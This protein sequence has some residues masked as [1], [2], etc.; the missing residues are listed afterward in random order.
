MQT[1]TL[2]QA[3]FLRLSVL[4]LIAPLLTAA[5]AGIHGAW[6][7]S[8]CQGWGKATFDYTADTV[9]TCL[10]SDLDVNAGVNRAGKTPL[11]GAVQLGDSDAVWLLLAA[12]ANPNK[13]DRKG[14]TPLMFAA[15]AG[16]QEII[17]QL[18]KAG[19]DPNLRNEDG[20]T[21]LLLAIEQE[22][23]AVLGPL[24]AAGAPINAAT[25]LWIVE[26]GP[27]TLIPS[28]AAAGVNLDIRFAGG[29]TL[30][31]RAAQMGQREVVEQLI[32]LGLDPNRETENRETALIR[33]AEAGHRDIV[34]YLLPFSDD[35]GAGAL[36][37]A[38]QEG[39]SNAVKQFLAA[40]VNP[41]ATVD[42]GEWGR[43]CTP[44]YYAASSGHTA[45]VK[46]FLTA[47]VD[48]NSQCRPLLAAAGSGHLGVV[49]H[50]LRA[51]A[52]VNIQNW[53]Q[54]TALMQAAR[55]GHI[56]IVE[57][58][59]TANADV[60]IQDEDGRTALMYATIYDVSNQILIVERLIA[61]NADPSLRDKRGKTA[62]D[63]AE[64]E[65][66]M[67]DAYGLDSGYG[68][69]QGG[70]IVKILRAATPKSRKGW[71]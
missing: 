21:A 55:W 69:P 70:A 28:L 32:A 5:L 63:M 59:I 33:A 43:S 66:G 52:G 19:A 45:I 31:M 26:Q 50:L 39:R 16:H 65:K 64:H 36:L 57:Q 49:E 71:W 3:Q 14:W 60:N 58:L 20:K 47:G 7:A 44:F 30:L 8:P 62:L 48:P 34:E 68:W 6:A 42:W 12:G 37:W 4:L 15:Q 18:A 13:Q 29:E 23:T 38:V 40:G 53:K 41:S 25:L 2:R 27:P 17:H 1:N 9:E 35:N 61:A 51:G 11:I 24:E 56:A 22:Q 54:E 46:Q 10:D 67:S